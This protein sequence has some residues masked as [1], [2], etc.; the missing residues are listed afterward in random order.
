MKKIQW[1]LWLIGLPLLGI[2]QDPH[3]SLL[4][5]TPITINPAYSGLI[6]GDWKLNLS[7][8]TRQATFESAFNTYLF[9]ADRKVEIDSVTENYNLHGGVGVMA[10]TDK[11]GNMRTNAF[12]FAFSY[13]V[14][15][16]I[17]IRY[18]HLRAGFNLALLQKTIEPPK[19]VFEDQY[20]GIGFNL[21]TQ[22][23][24][25]NR[26]DMNFDA[27][28]GFLYYRTQKIPGNLELNPWAGF[29]IYHITR[30]YV[31]FVSA[32]E[33]AKRTT[34]RYTFNAG[35]KLR[36]RTPLDL[37]FH[38]LYM[39]QNHSN[40][41]NFALYGRWAFYEDDYKFEKEKAAVRLGMVFRPAE[42]IVFDLGAEFHKRYHIGFA[43]DININ[44]YQLLRNSYGGLQFMLCYLIGG[45]K[46]TQPALPFPTF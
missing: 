42:S 27:G 15:L 43:Y 18:H 39:N 40:L 20:D 28:A 24:I 32:G 17:K 44:R 41:W 11:G 5:A 46:Y 2:A 16:G 9:Q 38:F 35:A 23:P 31:G 25:T 3:Y 45:K 22:E 37:N 6:E 7:H 4:Y 12:Q 29:S 13:E 34:I 10:L 21:Q 14:P 30:P 36:T 19:M 1:F 33:P 8:R 26:S